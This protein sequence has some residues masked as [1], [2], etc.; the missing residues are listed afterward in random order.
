MRI[1]RSVMAV[2]LV[3][4]AAL[5]LWSR[6]STHRAAPSPRSPV[7]I[8]RAAVSGAF[9]DG[10][11][12]V[13][14]AIAFY[15]LLSLV[16]A[17]SVVISVYGLLTEPAAIPAQIAALDVPIPAELRTL[18]LDQA[19]RIATTSTATL[20]M[21]VATSVV[22]A[23]WSANAA[24]KAMFEGLGRMWNRRETRSFLQF[25][26]TTLAFTLVAALTVVAMLAAFAM[27]PALQA[28]VG[29]RL[30]PILTDL[31]WP[32][33][34]GLGF[35]VMLLLYRR[36]PD[37][38]PPAVAQQIPGALFATSAWVGAS[39]A[40]SWYAAT[41]GTYSATYGSLA[42]VVVVLTWSW[43]SSI[44]VLLGGAITAEVERVS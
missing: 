35:T 2:A 21:T 25:Q 18:I 27:L 24:V 28:L 1:G 13:A 7:A 6:P 31:R 14:A 43:L 36:G 15:I 4:G 23:L 19:R 22:I 41:L 33:L 32:V 10:V 29:D 40:F 3:A 8:V 11:L 37:R 34:L 30:P 42:G 44:I 26:A 17:L 16:P 5:G 9:A 12:S 38:D 20:S 39:W